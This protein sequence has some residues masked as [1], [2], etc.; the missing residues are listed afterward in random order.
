MNILAVAAV[1][2][3]TV[4]H[5][6]I[7]GVFIEEFK[8]RNK[9]VE[10]MNKALVQDRSAMFLIQP[11]VLTIEAALA[12]IFIIHGDVAGGGTILKGGNL[13]FVN[14]TDSQI[15]TLGNVLHRVGE[16]AAAQL[17][18]QEGIHHMQYDVIVFVENK[19]TI[20]YR[21]VRRVA[22][23]ALSTT[24]MWAR[25]TSWLARIILIVPL[26]CDVY[27]VIRHSKNIISHGKR[28]VAEV[29]RNYS[30]LI[31]D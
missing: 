28:L 19:Q 23:L 25:V 30:F 7:L 20:S 27:T 18:F 29:L 14:L 17:I 2:A 12:G 16:E 5:G 15:A 24:M 10:G 1:E 31:F 22:A 26:C 11:V 9:V 13:G 21:A 8:N 6:K 4:H 3:F